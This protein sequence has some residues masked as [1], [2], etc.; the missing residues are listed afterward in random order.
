MGDVGEIF[1]RHLNRLT[2]EQIKKYHVA[3]DIITRPGFNTIG[4]EINVGINAFPITHFPTKTVYQYD[5]SSFT[6]ITEYK[7]GDLLTIDSG[8]YWKRCRETPCHPKG[9]GL[10]RA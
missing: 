7:T 4:K 2:G 9:V 6:I 3:S 8:S 5:V 1:F 10:Q